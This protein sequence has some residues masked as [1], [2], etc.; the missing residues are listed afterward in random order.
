MVLVSH[1]RDIRLEIQR[2]PQKISKILVE[3]RDNVASLTMELFSRKQI[4]FFF[5][6]L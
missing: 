2:L 1:G 3:N 5:R 4:K 6:L